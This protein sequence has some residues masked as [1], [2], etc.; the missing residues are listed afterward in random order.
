MFAVVLAGGYAKRLW[1]LTVNRPKALLPVAGKPVIDYVI[2]KLARLNLKIGRIVVS[3]NLRF[4]PQFEDW[5][6]ARIG[7]TQGVELMVESSV[8]EEDKLGAVRA[9]AEVVEEVGEE[10]VLVLPADNLFADD[11]EGFVRFFREKHASI[12]ALFDARSVD[13]A[14]KGS[15]VAV[16]EEGRVVEFVEKPVHPKTTLVGAA[17]YAFPAG[18]HRRLKQYLGL[19]LSVN[20]PGR[21]VEWL[22][23]Q[24]PV[25]GYMF[26]DYVWDIGTMESYWAADEFFSNVK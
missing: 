8:K 10:D 22:Y 25:Y 19:G 15:S 13:E 21:F 4:Q 14:R 6:G 12:V 23:E 7:R 2:E 24:E 20:E 1:P 9:L 16:D 18:I 11:L 5:L 26:K 3:T 17:I